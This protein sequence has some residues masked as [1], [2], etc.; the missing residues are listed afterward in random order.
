MHETRTLIDG[1]AA[2]ATRKACKVH[3]CAHALLVIA[4]HGGIARMQWR[5]VIGRQ[6][7]VGLAGCSGRA[8]LMHLEALEH[9]IAIFL[10]R[11][12]HSPCLTVLFHLAAK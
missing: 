2:V 5:A 3:A 10:L 11:E 8:A 12:A 4:N 7:H 9:I 6:M 1:K